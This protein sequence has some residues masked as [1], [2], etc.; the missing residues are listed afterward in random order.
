MSVTECANRLLRP[1]IGQHMPMRPVH[2]EAVGLCV[3]GQL[4][5]WP[6]MASLTP[7]ESF[8]V[9]P[10]A[11]ATDAIAPTQWNAGKPCRQR[12]GSAVMNEENGVGARPAEIRGKP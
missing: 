7:E 11:A 3:A 8:P 12:L 6:L 1:V 2:T 5:V 4:A 10:S 9:Q